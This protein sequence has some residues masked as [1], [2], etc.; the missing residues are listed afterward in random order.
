MALPVRPNSNGESKPESARLSVDSAM[1]PLVDVSLPELPPMASQRIVS[2]PAVAQATAPVEV[3]DDTAQDG[4]EV[5]AE[6]G[7]KFKQLVGYKSGVMKH[8]A[9]IIKAG[10]M[11]LDQLRK[12]IEEDPDFDLD[13]LNGSAETFLSHLR[14]PP[15]K[16]EQK[17]LKEER[18][19]RQKA[20]DAVNARNAAEAE[21]EDEAS[22]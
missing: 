17:R 1:P 14:V 2:P 6:T 9:N 13:D 16:E 21:A 4:W 15:D 5:D 20:Y 12:S 11:T 8:S 10:G 7:K 22:W 18:A 19:K 3:A